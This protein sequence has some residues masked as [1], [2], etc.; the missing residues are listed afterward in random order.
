MGKGDTIERNFGI[1][2]SVIEMEIG[3]SSPYD[4]GSQGIISGMSQQRKERT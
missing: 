1:L 3:S 4:R 2:K